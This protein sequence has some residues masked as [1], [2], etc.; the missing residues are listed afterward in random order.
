[1]TMTHV[2]FPS[3]GETLSAYFDELFRATEAPADPK[4]KDK[5]QEPKTLKA[6]QHWYCHQTMKYTTST[7][8]AAI[9]KQGFFQTM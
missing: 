9:E 1:M 5:P 4:D 2:S 3:A 8:E 6:D 7:S